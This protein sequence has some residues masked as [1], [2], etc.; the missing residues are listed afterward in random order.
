M[1]EAWSQLLADFRA[2]P[3][4]ARL[5][6]TVE[7]SP[8]HREANVAVHTELVL[9]AYETG[10]APARSALEQTITRLALLFHDTGKPT[11]EVTKH[12]P[13]LGTYRTYAGHEL[14][15]AREWVE[16]ALEHRQT[17]VALGLTPQVIS[18][19][20]FLIEHHLPYKLQRPEKLAALRRAVLARLGSYACFSDV[21]LSDAKG[22]IAD[23]HERKL[24]NTAAWVEAFE[25]GEV[26]PVPAV[27]AGREAYLLSGPTGAGKSTFAAT[28]KDPV[29]FSLDACRLELL[30]ATAAPPKEAYAAA[31][32]K[33]TAEPAA[34][35]K[36][37][38]ASLRAAVATAERENRPLVIDNTNLT[39]RARARY[40]ELLRSRRF[41]VHGVSF[42]ARRATLLARQRTRLDKEVPEAV[43][44]RMWATQ[45]ELL[46]GTECDR[47]LVVAEGWDGADGAFFNWSPGAVNGP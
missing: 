40:V 18:A 41:F 47:L 34:F 9:Q 28:L 42:Y 26:A 32:A 27:A 29:R 17:M 24:A 13:E 2:S 43:V 1:S 39:R 31:F 12:S 33:A 15:S 23:D 46:L 20:A 37:V 11:A 6:S 7:A 19:V 8:W 21:L 45:E 3:T 14:L 5:A 35:D 22:R 4:Y 16:Y 10:P 30:G 44:N 25:Q 38:S 36:L